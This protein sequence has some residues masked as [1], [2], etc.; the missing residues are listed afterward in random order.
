MERTTSAEDFWWVMTFV[1]L[2]GSTIIGW[3]ARVVRGSAMFSANEAPSK[4]RTGGRGLALSCL[5]WCAFLSCSMWQSWR[6]TEGSTNCAWDRSEAYA[7]WERNRDAQRKGDTDE[8]KSYWCTLA[9]LSL[10]FLTV[11]TSWAVE[12]IVPPEEWCV[13]VQT[14]MVPCVG[15]GNNHA[16]A[17]VPCTARRLC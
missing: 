10:L 9:R 15:V 3:Y 11:S 8:G 7:R 14:A 4:Q 12:S 17:A 13:Y 5:R 2:R 16:N 6:V 1:Y